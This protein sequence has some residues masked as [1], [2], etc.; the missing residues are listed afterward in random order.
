[1]HCPA[2]ASAVAERAWAGAGGLVGA[3]PRVIGADLAAAAGWGRLQGRRR[4]GLGRRRRRVGQALEERVREVRARQRRLVSQRIHGQPAHSAALQD[5]G[6]QQRAAHR[7]RPAG[8]PTGR[9]SNAVRQLAW[10]SRSAHRQCLP[11]GPSPSGLLQSATSG[12]RTTGYRAAAGPRRR[13]RRPRPGGSAGRG[14]RPRAAAAP[15]PAPRAPGTRTPAGASRVSAGMR[16]TR[17]VESTR[18]RARPR[19]AVQAAKL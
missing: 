3:R 6:G 16:L 18:H 14:S 9:R 10:L 13:G 17:R 8:K 2:A 11:L 12:V 5:G 15:P 4:G 7:V 1:M 19:R